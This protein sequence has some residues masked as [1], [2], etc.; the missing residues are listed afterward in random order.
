MDILEVVTK[1]DLELLKEQARAIE[2]QITYLHEECV[3]VAKSLKISAPEEKDV[4]LLE[5]L[6]ELVDNIIISLEE[7]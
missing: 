1:I 3:T 5:G 2:K 6:L 4:E 7:S